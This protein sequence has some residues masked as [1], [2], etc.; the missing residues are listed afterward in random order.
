MAENYLKKYPTSLVI[1]ET[2]M[3]TILRFHLIQIR[4]TKIKNSGDCRMLSRMWRKEH[5]SISGGIA[6]WYNHY[7]NNFGGSSEYWACY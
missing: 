3:K 2:K 5:S 4:K 1:W 7:G 6:S